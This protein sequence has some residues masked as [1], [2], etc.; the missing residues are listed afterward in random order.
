MFVYVCRVWLWV[1]MCVYKCL[2]VCCVCKYEPAACYPLFIQSRRAVHMF[3][4]VCAIVCVYHLNSVCM[5]ECVSECV[6]VC[7]RSYMCVLLCVRVCYCVP[8]R[9]ALFC[10]KLCSHRADIDGANLD[11]RP[12]WPPA[13]DSACCQHCSYCFKSGL[14]RSIYIRCVYGVFGREITTYTVIYG[15]YIRFWPTLL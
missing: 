4:Y 6:F 5:C 2:R 7:A 9:Y 14:A 15:V 11:S 13:T 12:I 3:V 1:R 10:Y 8:S